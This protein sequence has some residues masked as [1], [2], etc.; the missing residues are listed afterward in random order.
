LRKPFLRRMGRGGFSREDV[1]MAIEQLD[2]S[3]AR[4]ESALAEGAWLVGDHYSIADICMAPLLQ[5]LDDLGMADMWTADRP[6]VGGWY[7]RIR[8]RDAYRAA[9]YP[10]SLLAD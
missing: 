9:F 1:D 7:E 3:L 10:G 6:R 4:M 5:R 2:Q 8:A